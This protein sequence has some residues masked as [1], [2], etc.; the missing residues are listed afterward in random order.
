MGPGGSSG[1]WF[2]SSVW[3]R[4]RW[5]RASLVSYR[6][7]ES[8]TGFAEET[9]GGRSKLRGWRFLEWCI[10]SSV[11]L[12]FAV[13]W[14]QKRCV[15]PRTCVMAATRGDFVVVRVFLLSDLPAFGVCGRGTTP[16][17]GF[18]MA[19]DDGEGSLA[20]SCLFTHAESLFTVCFCFVCLLLNPCNL[21]LPF[22][23]VNRNCVTRRI[24]LG[25]GVE[26]I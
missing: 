6:D 16:S 21:G 26:L 23:P 7:L 24:P 20:I 25:F 8:C 2:Q 18:W 15:V 3:G 10:S 19:S 14:I 22:C 12:P 17:A 5:S 9:V 13:V 4:Q 1:S 11:L